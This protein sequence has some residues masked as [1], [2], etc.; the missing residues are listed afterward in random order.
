MSDER[1]GCGW[2]GLVVVALLA[3]IAP[4][5]ALGLA[6]AHCPHAAARGWRSVGGWRVAT[7]RA[8]CPRMPRA[9][10]QCVGLALVCVQ[11]PPAPARLGFGCWLNKLHSAHA[12]GLADYQLFILQLLRNVLHHHTSHRRRRHIAA[13][14]LHIAHELRIGFL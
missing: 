5:R 13:A 9:I 3:G 4:S 10:C 6:D 11:Q 2:L 1:V 14:I 12:R 7:S 8:Q